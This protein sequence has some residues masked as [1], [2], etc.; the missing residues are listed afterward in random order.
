M[1]DLLIRNLERFGSLSDEE[2]CVLEEAVSGVREVGTD[3]DIVRDG[4]RPLDS[5]LVLDGFLCRYR[6]MPDGKRQIM[7]FLIPGDIIDLQAF[8]LQEMDHSIRS[9]TP[10]KLAVIPHAI[11][12]EITETQPR[13]TRALW[14]CSLVEAALF[15]TWIA[16]IGRNEA[17][18]RM[19]HLLC[20]MLLRLKVVGLAKDDN[21]AF[22]ITQAELGDALGLSA[23]HINRVLQQLRS[24][25]LITLN[26]GTL[27]VKNWEGLRNA[28]QFDPD[29]LHLGNIAPT[30]GIRLG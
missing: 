16:N 9:L 21:C 6:L 17:Y 29:Y 3:R 13:L 23:V 18:Q 7:S 10:C 30:Y 8:L 19:A 11:L 20:E 27:T 4:D 22:P 12:R 5:K 25:G 28:G 1:I 26:G 2:R 24:D 15:R 14:Q